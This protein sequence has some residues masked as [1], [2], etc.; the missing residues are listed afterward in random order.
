MGGDVPVRIGGL[1][2][3]NERRTLEKIPLLGDI[4]LLGNL[5][6]SKGKARARTNLMVFIRPTILGSAVYQINILIGTGMASFLPEG[7]VSYLYYADRLFQFPL[8]VFGVAVGVATLPSL[9]SLAAPDRREEFRDTLA[10]S[11][12]L[13]L[14]VV[15]LGLNVLALRIVQK[16]REQY[17]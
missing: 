2:D 3:D 1:L 12:G 9:S 7:S 10:S 5:F 6:R 17:D 4:P 11:L 16:Y 8:G 15:T 14:F 13:T